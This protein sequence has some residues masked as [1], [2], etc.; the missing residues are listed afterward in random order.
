MKTK[1][2]TKYHKIIKI[3]HIKNFHKETD[4]NNK[5]STVEL[6]TL[7]T[8]KNN[9]IK[10]KEVNFNNKNKTVLYQIIYHLLWF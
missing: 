7:I 8:I 9:N 2:I 4:Q 10:L 1:I 3:N 6:T 5:K